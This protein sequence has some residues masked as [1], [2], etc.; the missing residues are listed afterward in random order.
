MWHEI[1]STLKEV[2]VGLHEDIA[3]LDP[4]TEATE[5]ARKQG[6]LAMAVWMLAQ[7]EAIL[8]EIEIE[9]DKQVKQEKGE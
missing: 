4:N 6:R 9:N 5:L 8:E 1:K 2:I 7:P 3:N